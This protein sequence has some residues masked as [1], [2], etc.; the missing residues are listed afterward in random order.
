AA[1]P[2]QRALASSSSCRA[3]SR[4]IPPRALR[5]VASSSSRSAVRATAPTAAS[6]RRSTRSLAGSAMRPR[7]APLPAALPLP[8]R[9]RRSSSCAVA[10]GRSRCQLRHRGLLEGLLR[11]LL[12]LDAELLG[13]LGRD[14]LDALAPPD[15]LGGD[16]PPEVG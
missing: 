11:G 13:L 4:R 14:P 16:A 15:R 5:S 7:A 2:R 12:D 1:S 10:S 8:L 9:L 3:S 6:A